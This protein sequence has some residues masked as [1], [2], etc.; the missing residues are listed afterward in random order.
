MDQTG[1]RSPSPRQRK[2]AMTDED[3]EAVARAV[4]YVHALPGWRSEW[5]DEDDAVR[6][7]YIA[8]ARAAIAADPGRKD[9]PCIQ[10]RATTILRA[11]GGWLATTP[12]DSPL[13]IGVVGETEEGA[14]EALR[15]A[16]LRWE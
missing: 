14:R 8:I 16:L 2:K 9:Y 13:K 6:R 11:C 15:I 10:V 7:D 4:F 12:S 3:V 1:S 5:E